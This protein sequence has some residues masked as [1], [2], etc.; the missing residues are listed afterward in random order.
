MPF[1]AKIIHYTLPEIVI[2]PPSITTN[3]C[4]PV[5]L[6]L[7]GTYQTFL[8]DINM[9]FIEEL[10]VQ[11]FLNLTQFP[12]L[13][14]PKSGGSEGVNLINF[15]FSYVFVSKYTNLAYHARKV[16]PT[17]HPNSRSLYALYR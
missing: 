7:T 5:Y 17:T 8:L 9:I 15:D 11:I 1:L 16:N 14:T 2:K 13:Q 12:K 4:L 3:A 6:V 10:P